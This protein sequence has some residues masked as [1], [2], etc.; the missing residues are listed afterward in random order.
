MCSSDLMSPAQAAAAVARLGPES[1]SGFAQPVTGA[2][3]RQVPS[4]YVVCEQDLSVHPNH[5][6][7]MAARCTN[8]VSLDTDHSPFASMPR[9]T[10]AILAATTRA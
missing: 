8:V 3:W 2:P 9:E 4:T 7:S 6:R 5:Q 10:A 1:S